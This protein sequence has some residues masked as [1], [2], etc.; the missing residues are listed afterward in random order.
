MPLSTPFYDSL[1]DSIARLGGLYNAHLHLC[2]ANSLE[3]TLRLLSAPNAGISSIS[4]PSKH[5]LIP[6]VHASELY[7]AGNLRARVGRCLDEMAACNTRRADTLVDVTFDRVRLSALM[8]FLEMKAERKSVLDL[9]VG[10]YSPLGFNDAEPERWHLLLEG[11]AQAD[12]IGALPE[13]D[14]RSRYPD[15][16]GYAENCR[17]FLELSQT[18]GKTLHIHVDQRNHPDER[19]TEDFLDVMDKMGVPTPAGEPSIWL[20]HFISP[21]AYEEGRFRELVSR[22]A[23]RNVGVICCPSA[24]LSMRQ[25]RSTTTP[26]HNSIA[27]V[28]ELLEAKVRVAIASDNI[29]DLTSPGSTTDLLD[30]I[31]VLCNALRFYDIEILAKLAT[32]T[33]LSDED[34]NL[35]VSHLQQD[36]VEQERSVAIAPYL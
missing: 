7:E 27:R 8:M 32:G 24:A 4:L 26:T 21:S 18:T 3:T 28:L 10:A 16:I 1:R 9:R 12:F 31:F 2:R 19:G 30:E 6:M 25:L 33:L 17:R 36:R 15:N 14:D 11:I 29:C 20:I 35:I 23:E 13:R 34:R 5:A 22:M